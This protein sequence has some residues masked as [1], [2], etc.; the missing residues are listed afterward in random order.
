MPP[1]NPACAIKAI[2]I[3][4]PTKIH[5]FK[6][7]VAAKKA[8]LQWH[9]KNVGHGLLK[10]F[11]ERKQEAYGYKWELVH[12][13]SSVNEIPVEA[14]NIFT[15][16][17]CVENIFNGGKVR[18]TN[19]NP[20]RASVFDVISIVTETPNPRTAFMRMCNDY[21]DV[22][23]YTNNF[24]FAG[25]GQRDTPV[26]NAEGILYI[27]NLLPGRRA[28]LFR[29][30]AVKL[31]V[32]FL[33]GDQSLIEEITSNAHAQSTLSESNPM[34]MFSEEVYAHP[35]S[36]K[37]VIRSPSM[38]GKFLSDFYKK[39]VVYLLT[40]DYNDK[41]YIKVGRSDD[42]KDRMDRHFR[43][44]PGCSVYSIVTT[45]NANRLEKAWKESFTAHNEEIE[46]NGK[47]KTELFIGI[48]PETAESRL[49]DLCN[50]MALYNKQNN[51]VEMVKLKYAHELALKTHE[52]ALK[53]KEIE[54][55]KLQLQLC[56]AQAQAQS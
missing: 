34:Q 20:R 17:D 6:S 29:L 46:V 10:K 51:E 5:E 1:F 13:D 19:E 7:L 28:A 12:D 55:V 26:A 36:N 43:E 18:I 31:L 15:F 37:Y 44:L 8:M 33:A 27:V 41:Q 23:A 22:V 21:D 54:L 9:Q 24:K 35:R 4:D 38:A 56:Q 39:P 48:T 50:E 11:A 25:M 32:R 14:E 2:D 3:T 53:D 49:Y 47:I 42:I 40:F 45:D 16:R 30:H 52:L